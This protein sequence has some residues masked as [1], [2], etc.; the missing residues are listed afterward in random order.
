MTARGDL[1]IRWLDIKFP[2]APPKTVGSG[3]PTLVTWNG[4]LRG[5]SFAV[6]DAHDFDP[7]EIEHNALI[8]SIA[9]WHLHLVSRDSEVERKVNYQ[10]E[11]TVEPPSGIIP[12]PTTVSAELTI[13]AS[14]GVNTVH[15]LNISTFSIESIAR[16]VYARITR[17][18][19]TATEPTTDPLIGA[20]HF[21][22]Q[23]DDRGSRLITTK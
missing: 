5:Y 21:H 15:R 18:A 17:I 3:N 6:G 7:Q 20:L 8:G 9:T 22:Y 1:G 16:L 14:S 11:Y 10:L 23:T 4:N 12:A 2:M 19:S 13:P